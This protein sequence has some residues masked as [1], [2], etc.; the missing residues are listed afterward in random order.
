MEIF[1]LYVFLIIGS[2]HRDVELTA[3]PSTSITS[4]RDTGSTEP[5]RHA[6]ERALVCLGPLLGGGR[7]SRTS[8]AG[9]GTATPRRNS[10]ERDRHRMQ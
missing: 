10:G 9:P 5:A 2:P 3:S 7:W 1:S 6:D 4:V 8:S